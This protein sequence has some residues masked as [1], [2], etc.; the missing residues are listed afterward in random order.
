MLPKFLVANG[1]MAFSKW[2]YFKFA[3][4]LDILNFCLLVFL[5]LVLNLKYEIKQYINRIKTGNLLNH[6][7][8]KFF[9]NFTEEN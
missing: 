4:F 7:T 3:L 5:S 2:L 8:K 1:N 6:C 9:K